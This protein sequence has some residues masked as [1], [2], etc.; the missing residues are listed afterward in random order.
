MKCKQFWSK[1]T[2]IAQDEPYRLNNACPRL[3]EARELTNSD[4][5]HDLR[6]LDWSDLRTAYL[7]GEMQT[8]T[9]A[10]RRL[11]V[12]RSTLMRQITSLENAL[13]L[14]IFERGLKG[15]M[16]TP[17]GKELIDLA[18]EAARRFEQLVPNPPRAE[19]SQSGVLKIAAPPEL[20]YIIS[21]TLPKLSDKFPM[22]WFSFMTLQEYQAANPKDVDLVFSVGDSPF[23]VDPNICL[24]TVPQSLFAS[25][26]YLRSFGI[27]SAKTDYCSHKFVHHFSSGD[28]TRMDAWLSKSVSAENIIFRSNSRL[29]VYSAIENG[30][31]IGACLEPIA[32]RKKGLVEICD[33]RDDWKTSIWASFKSAPQRDPRTHAVI[34]A[35]E[36]RLRS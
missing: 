22:L 12:H 36:K 20:S 26:K 13:G 29:A 7:V 35:I 17:F 32:L 3:K 1:N 15:Y 24:A 25:P 28:E 10:A 23:T 34:S 14:K 16:P 19:S 11:G 6:H 21:S 4:Q 2:L 30:L 18:G 33:P 5:I 31:G 8:L 9:R 27:P